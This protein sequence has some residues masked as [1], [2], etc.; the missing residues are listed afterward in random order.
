MSENKK[1][2]IFVSS[3]LPLED[4]ESETGGSLKLTSASPVQTRICVEATGEV[5]VQS[6]LEEMSSRG[7]LFEYEVDGP[8]KVNEC[9]LVMIDRFSPEGKAYEVA[10]EFGE[11]VVKPW[12][13]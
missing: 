9:P 4:V 13:R 12:P 10:V 8:V 5:D 1:S 3:G 7:F 6:L 2:Y 11:L